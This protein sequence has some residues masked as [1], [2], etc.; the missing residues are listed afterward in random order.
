M[1]RL[2]L[3]LLSGPTI[4][5]S[6]LCYLSALPATAAPVNM[7]PDS[8][9]CVWSRHS[10]TNLVCTRVKSILEVQTQ[11]PV[12]LASN[13]DTSPATFEFS[14]EEGNAAIALFGCDCTVCIN[15]LRTLRSMANHG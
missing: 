11:E 14:N 7:G 8:Q 3:T 13:P 9:V 2:I 10:R 5:S 4:V 12:D 15:S 6:A 1:K